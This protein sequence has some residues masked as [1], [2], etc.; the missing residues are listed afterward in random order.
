M[1]E[2]DKYKASYHVD[3]ELPEITDTGTAFK[4][5]KTGETVDVKADSLVLSLDTT[6]NTQ[7]EEMLKGKVENL[8][9]AGNCDGA[10][11][12]LEGTS[13]VFDAVWNL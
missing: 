2:L 1:Q 3:M 13:K 7:G 11:R 9:V 4:N 12:L 10:T 5:T 8:I 6:P